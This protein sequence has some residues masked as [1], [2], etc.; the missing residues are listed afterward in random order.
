MTNTMGK[1]QG[2]NIPR[3]QIIEIALQQAHIHQTSRQG[4]AG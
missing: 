3:Y 4:S 2:M 1:K